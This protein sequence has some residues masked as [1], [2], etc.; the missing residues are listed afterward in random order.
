[1]FDIFIQ[2]ITMSYSNTVFAGRADNPIA[3]P[4]V[5]MYIT[6]VKNKDTPTLLASYLPFFYWLLAFFYNRDG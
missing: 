3:F 5:A 6:I 1:M 2:P 4:L